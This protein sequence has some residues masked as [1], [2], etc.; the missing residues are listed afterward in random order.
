MDTPSTCVFFVDFIEPLTSIIGLLLVVAHAW[1]VS[2]PIHSAR[3]FWSTAL[4]WMPFMGLN[5][6]SSRLQVVV[7]DWVGQTRRFDSPP[8]FSINTQGRGGVLSIDHTL[9][10]CS[11]YYSFIV[12]R[13]VRNNFQHVWHIQCPFR[14][15]HLHNSSFPPNRSREAETIHQEAT[16]ESNLAG[17]HPGRKG[18]PTREKSILKVVRDVHP[19]YEP[20]VGADIPSSVFFPDFTCS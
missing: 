14:R 5:L 18:D 10:L 2:G 13:S 15:G 20:K 12:D 19:L 9:L 4:N 8:F 3:P 6:L 1:A 7:L 17:V 16:Q 11:S